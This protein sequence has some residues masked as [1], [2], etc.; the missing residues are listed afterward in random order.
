AAASDPDPKLR[1]FVVEFAGGNLGDMGAEAPLTPRLT[2]QNG[3]VEHQFVQ[4]L[5]S[6]S[7][8]AVLDIARDDEEIPVEFIL[9]LQLDGTDVTETWMYQWSGNR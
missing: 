1:K 4:R 9:A 6:G 8:R 3:N 2:L 5:E 7:W